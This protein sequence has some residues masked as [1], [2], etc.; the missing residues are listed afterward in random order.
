MGIPPVRVQEEGAQGAKKKSGA[1]RADL[2]FRHCITTEGVLP[3]GPENDGEWRHHSG[4]IDRRLPVDRIVHCSVIGAM[5]EPGT[6]APALDHADGP[7]S[8]QT[9]H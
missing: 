9:L 4:P 5:L 8:A 1:W 3:D 2:S 6:T 7:P